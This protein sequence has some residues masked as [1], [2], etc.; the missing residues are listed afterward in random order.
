MA[1]VANNN[2]PV[3]VYYDPEK[4]QYFTYKTD[5]TNPTSAI[6]N[7]FGG[8]GIVPSSAERVYLGS[9]Y[10]DTTASTAPVTM[11]TMA[12]A[13]AMDYAAIRGSATTPTT[14]SSGYEY[15]PL[16]DRLAAASAFTSALPTYGATGPA[17]IAGLPTFGSVTAPTTIP[18][19]TP[20]TTP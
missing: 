9:P 19:T 20:T 4:G 6:T 3:Q 12:Y 18:S 5:P 14:A 7:V 11:P 1:T 17:P 13:P 16:A 15:R 10:G 2:A 8:L